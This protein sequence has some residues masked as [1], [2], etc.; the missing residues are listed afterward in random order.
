MKNYNDI[1]Y[2]PHPEPKSHKRMTQRDRAAQFSPFAALTGYEDVVAETARLTDKRLELSEDRQTK[3]NECLQAI[4]EKISERP[5]VKI[6]Y[7]LPDKLKSGGGYTVK[8]GFVKWIDEVE[9]IVI[10]TDNFSI[11]IADIYDIDGDLFR[12]FAWEIEE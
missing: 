8:I 7:F 3:I 6:T 12:D 1:I 9:K 11:P 4:L 2:L 10:F 5:E